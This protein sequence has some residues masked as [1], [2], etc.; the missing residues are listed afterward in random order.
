MRRRKVYLY[1][2]KLKPRSAR[3]P[4]AELLLSDEG[5]Y[6]PWHCGYELT[7][8]YGDADLLM[9]PYDLSA[10]EDNVDRALG[11]LTHLHGLRKD[12]SSLI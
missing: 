12:M 4:I 8:C 9:L 6:G 5:R 10:Y 7:T 2:V 11:V 1:S 3:N